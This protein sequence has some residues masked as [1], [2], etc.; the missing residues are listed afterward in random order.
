LLEHASTATSSKPSA[1]WLKGLDRLFDELGRDAARTQLVLWF[2]LAASPETV[3]CQTGDRGTLEI[4]YGLPDALRPN[5]NTLRGLAWAASCFEDDDVARAVGALAET[6]FKKIPNFGP[7]RPVVGNACLEALSR[8]SCD[9]AAAEIS[10]L[11]S[12]VKNPSARKMVAKAFGKTADRRGVSQLELEEAVV[13]HHGL[14]KGRAVLGFGAFQAEILLDVDGE[15]SLQWR[16]AGDDAKRNPPAELKRDHPDAAAKARQAK[17]DLEKT[18]AGQRARL[19]RLFMREQEWPLDRWR[20]HY[21][22]HP[23]VGCLARRLIWTF[24]EGQARSTGAWDGTQLS[25]ASGR[26]LEL[27]SDAAVRLWHPLHATVPEVI[28]WRQ[29]L[30]SSQITQPTKQA[31]REVYLLT[32]AEQETATFSNRFAAHRLRQ[33]QLA[34]LCNERGWSYHLM[35]SF[36]AWSSPTLELPE[37]GFT[38]TLDLGVFSSEASDAGIFV[39]VTSD[40]VQFARVEMVEEMSP[41]LERA[42]ADWPEG[43]PH[44]PKFRALMRRQAR[45]SQVVRLQDVPP[46]VFSEVMRDVDLFVSTCSLGNDPRWADAQTARNEHWQSMVFGELGE[47]AKTRR[48]ALELLI[49]RLKIA[50]QCRFEPNFLVVEGKRAT[51]RIHFGSGNVMREPGS[52]FLCIVSASSPAYG[53]RLPFEGDSMLS[54]ILSKAFLLAADDCITDPSILQQL[55]N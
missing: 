15:V 3:A 50:S 35:G 48:A 31:Y 18:L 16:R 38:V 33:H 13:P 24:T 28:A 23:V 34:A 4:P 7:M 55:V 41:E 42:F 32:P 9:V 21:L 47:T 5:N 36:D 14:E 11:T 2:E 8:M 49:P 51:Y 6:C 27:R 53:V 1:R 22:D 54:L 20:E 46:R 26:P 29:W 30:A 39:E 52:R 25:D 44:S 45:R 19:E 10:R 40:R 43:L 12:R 17:K 37:H